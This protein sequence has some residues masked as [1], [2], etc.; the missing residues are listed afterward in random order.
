MLIFLA[1]M[2]TIPEELYESV[3]VD[4]ANSLQRYT[5]ITLPLLSPTMFLNMVLIVINS[6]QVF[7]L[8]SIMTDGGPCMSTNYLDVFNIL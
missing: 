5:K 4:G 1:G 7:D 8:I 6:F 2:Q 3:A